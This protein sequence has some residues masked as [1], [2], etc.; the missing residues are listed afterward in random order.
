M[1]GPL[2]DRIDIK[3]SIQSVSYQDAT[4]EAA[5]T[6]SADLYQGVEKALQAQ[7]KRFGNNHTFNSMMNTQEVSDFCILTPDAKILLEK[8]FEKLKLSM[9]SYHKILKLA[10][11]IA[12]IQEA[13]KIEPLHIQKAIMY[14]S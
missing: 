5:S 10:R 13:E 3:I 6:S 1:S 14:K 8:A 7:R 11:T 2:L 4:K 9:R 12:D